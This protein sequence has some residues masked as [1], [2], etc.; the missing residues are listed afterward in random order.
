[1]SY[2][3]DE[4]VDRKCTEAVK[5]S[6]PSGIPEDCIPLWVADM[7][8]RCPPEI[9]AAIIK[10]AE[11]GVFGYPCKYDEYFDAVID[12]MKEHHQWSVKKEWIVTSPGVVPAMNFSIRALLRP[13]DYI[14]IQR[15]VYTPFSVSIEQ[16]GSHVANSPLKLVGDRYEIDFDDFEKKASDPRV[17]MFFLCN[18]H[19]PVGRVWTRDELLRMG[20]I[21]VKHNVL[22]FSD[23]IHQDMVYTGHT[24]TPFASISPELSNITITA[25]APSKT[26]NIAGL[27]T[28][29]MIIENEQ[30]RAE[31]IRESE[32]SA[33]LEPNIFGIVATTAAYTHGHAWL[34]QV[35]AYIEANKDYVSEFIAE[36]LPMLK[37]IRAEATFMLWI[38][39]RG[40]G[41]ID[42][43]LRQFM[44]NE[45]HLWLNCG[46][47]YGEEGSGF[48]RINIGCPR[49]LL[50]KAMHN[51]EAG[52]HQLLA[53]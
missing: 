33:A 38:D 23:E 29:N 27:K 41:L 12:W 44:L 52:I 35:M 39:C 47:T 2:N 9:T 42:E 16:N 34:K 6:Y 37:V 49:P 25:T 24:H 21:C 50:E 10:R 11:H 36:R 43:Q 8:F 13:G 28:S 20:E 40:L 30:L 19:N 3:F 4:I 46:F 22:V 32:R 45:A 18:P 7:D 5:W 26:F 48:Q 14:L 15:P 31:F 1:M 53:K 17:K 51:L